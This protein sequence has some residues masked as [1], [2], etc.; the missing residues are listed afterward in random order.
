MFSW[1]TWYL[2]F[3]IQFE[4]VV[5]RSLCGTYLPV[6]R[7]GIRIAAK[8]FA[9]ATRQQ[10]GLKTIRLQAN[11][12]MTALQ[13]VYINDYFLIIHNFRVN[14]TA[15][16]LL[17]VLSKSVWLTMG[18]QQALAN[19]TKSFAFNILL[20]QYN[21]PTHLTSSFGTKKVFEKS[22]RKWKVHTLKIYESPKELSQKLLLNHDNTSGLT[23]KSTSKSCITLE[24][25]CC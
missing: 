21:R 9:A 12:L 22:D 23:L 17:C 8:H 20:L 15:S 1:K 25:L 6:V 19:H 14:Q 3:I 16:I 5:L 18:L 7:K 4:C 10:L 2:Y 24:M 11:F 13:N